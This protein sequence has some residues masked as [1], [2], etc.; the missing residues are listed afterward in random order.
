MTRREPDFSR[1]GRNRN[2]KGSNLLVNSLIGVVVL[3]IIIVAA[4]IIL[5][6]NDDENMAD[7]DLITANGAYDSSEEPTSPVIE[8]EEATEDEEVVDEPA[9]ENAMD[10]AASTESSAEQQEAIVK[11]ELE[12]NK[13]DDSVDDSTGAGSVTYITPDDEIIAETV[14]NASWQPI[15]TSQTGEHASQYDRASVDWVEKQQALA[16]ATGLSQDSMIFW[17]I[18]NGGGPQ[19]SVGIVSSTDKTK[20]Y[21]VYLEWID[22]EG[23]KPVKMDVLNTLDFDY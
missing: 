2:R 16:Y 18:K 8:D 7:S 19:K 4:T 13:D 11:P 22:G 10:E 6:N 17:K 3:L 21:R 9:T 15:G 14:I 23:W 5:G 20:K 12:V 1:S